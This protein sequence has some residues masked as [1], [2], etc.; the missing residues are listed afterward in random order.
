MT[1]A[2]YDALLARQGGGCAICGS[3]PKKRR[4]HVDHDHRT[5]VVRGL[6]CY[7]CNRMLPS[8]A[9]VQRLAAAVMYLE[10]GAPESGVPWIERVNGERSLR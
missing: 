1:P 7:A 10:Y 5:G 3:T 9:T 8:Y 4:L 6:L 2:E